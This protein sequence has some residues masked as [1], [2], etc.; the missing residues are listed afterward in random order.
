MTHLLHLL[1]LGSR[2]ELLEQLGLALLRHGAFQKLVT[3]V[4]EFSLDLLYLV[5]GCLLSEPLLKLA[6]LR[7]QFFHIL[8]VLAQLVFCS[9]LAWNDAG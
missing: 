3:D 1:R 9:G 7:S 8:T 6:L 4:S 2:R 5:V